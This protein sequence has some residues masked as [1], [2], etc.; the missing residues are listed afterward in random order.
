MIL[1]NIHTFWLS[2]KV[3]DDWVLE[4]IETWKNINP[5][6]KII[7]HHADEFLGLLDSCNYYRHMIQK[8]S[9]AY[10]T[11]Y[12]RS[13]ILYE[14]GGWY[15][16]ADVTCHKPLDEL[17]E[18][19]GKRNRWIGWEQVYPY[20][21][22]ECASMGFELH[23]PIM[24]ALVDYYENLWEEDYE[25]KPMPYI[26]NEVCKSNNI[27]IDNVLDPEVLSGVRGALIP[28]P[29]TIGAQA[30]KFGMDP[31]KDKSFTVHHFTHSGY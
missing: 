5:N 11:D 4:N 3:V 15:F 7:I 24:Q 17:E 21:T 27:S 16:D 9:W 22:V 1:K 2:S 8:K 23:D 28:L 19:Y 26:L 10:A 13:K 12:L 20:N 6:Y 14:Q 29:R 25:T 18:K 31:D 30:Y